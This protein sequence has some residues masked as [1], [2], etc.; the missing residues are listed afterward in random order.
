MPSPNTPLLNLSLLIDVTFSTPTGVYTHNP[1]QREESRPQLD[2]RGEELEATR[3]LLPQD[4]RPGL[5][6]RAIERFAGNLGNQR[7]Q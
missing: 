5:T 4:R 7:L 1:V 6:Q 3:F 2:C